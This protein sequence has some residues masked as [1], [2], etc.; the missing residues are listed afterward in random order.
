MEY[1]PSDDKLLKLAKDQVEFLGKCHIGFVK[2]AKE[3]NAGNKGDPKLHTLDDPEW[4]MYRYVKLWMPLVLNN[5]LERTESLGQKLVAPLDIAWL[6]HVH[7]LVPKS[8]L[9]FCRNLVKNTGEEKLSNEK[10][11][12]LFEN[13]SEMLDLCEEGD[14]KS[15]FTQQVWEKMFPDT[16]LFQ[17][18]R[19]NSVKEEL[20][21]LN[22][23]QKRILSSCESQ[24]SFLY[25]IFRPLFRKSEVMRSAYDD[26]FKFMLLI[27][28]RKSNFTVPRYD[29]DLMWHSHMTGSPLSY[30]KST[31]GIVGFHVSH[32]DTEEDRN[33]GSK[34][35]NS[36]NNTVKNWKE[37]YG[38]NYEK[39]GR[40][41]LGETPKEFYL[42][43][44]H[45]YETISLVPRDVFQ[46]HIISVNVLKDSKEDED[47]KRSEEDV[48]IKAKGLKTGGKYYTK[49]GVD[50]CCRTKEYECYREPGGLTAKTIQ[51]KQNTY[52]IGKSRGV[53]AA[54]YTGA[55]CGTVTD[56]CAPSSSGG[57]GWSGGG[58]CGGGG[59][60]GGGCGGGCGG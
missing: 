31:V 26:Y 11:L 59:C 38:E 56:P 48:R 24:R 5:G 23:M 52:S 25:Q 19:K 27:A 46:S 14:S 45:E 9:A 13:G 29:I 18:K 16:D 32:D 12:S 34:L 37:K 10:V 30:Y 57:G 58:G 53:G 42:P 50:C 1:F 55:V 47:K 28:D 39:P 49:K 20:L 44:E 8:Y 33:E 41:Y 35:F 54:A 60:G 7:R 17:M 2:L 22:N 36:F 15:N 51:F 6:W 4:S 43:S 3:R 40:G 21:V